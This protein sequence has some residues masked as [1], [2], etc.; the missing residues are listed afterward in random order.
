[1]AQK[2][3]T[4]SNP[5]GGRDYPDPS[6]MTRIGD[7]LRFTAIGTAP[8]DSADGVPVQDWK[9]IHV[10]FYGEV[11]SS[12]GLVAKFRPWRWYAK[13]VDG[14]AGVSGTEVGW[15]IPDFEVTVALDV[16]LVTGAISSH[17]AWPT[18]DA[19]K[20]FFEFLGAYDSHGVL[21]APPTFVT[22]QV[23]GDAR[24]DDPVC[25]GVSSVAGG[26]IVLPPAPVLQPF[27]ASV[28]AT[29]WSP[30]DGTATYFSAKVLTAAGWPFVVDD[31][32]CYILGIVVRQS[33]LSVIE[34][35]NGHNG[36]SIHAAAG[37][38]TIEG[39][40]TATPFL[41]GDLNYYVYVVYQ[42][43]AYTEATDSLRTEEIQP[44]NHEITQPAYIVN[45]QAVAAD[46]GVTYA[47]SADG[48]VMDGYKDIAFQLYL[49]GGIGAAAANRTVTVVFQGSNDVEVPAGTRQWDTLAVGYDL[50]TDLTAASWVSVG[51]VALV[52]QVDF[53]N[54]QHKR[55]R[56]MYDWDADPSVTNGMIVITERRKAL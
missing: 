3:D 13:Q 38:I 22:A 42:N 23:F 7:G 54:W 18:R 19:G 43:K 30:A 16:T 25:V 29:H 34:Y 47:P 49:L 10:I 17:L 41:I 15:W 6:N 9:S 46:P 31:A 52:T 24:Q 2:R 1:M 56:V 21:V 55:I 32:N 50:T 39:A 11:T 48:I 27:M 8:D 37:Q 53:D 26:G 44:L 20:M 51:N 33:A 28:G 45:L 36:I 5:F 12:A 14:H 35:V 40:P 4:Q